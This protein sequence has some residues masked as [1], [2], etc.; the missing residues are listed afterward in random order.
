MQADV[1][2]SMVVWVAVTHLPTIYQIT[3]SVH[4]SVI[5]VSPRGGERERLLIVEQQLSIACMFRR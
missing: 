5:V 2:V 4:G 3:I 1:G